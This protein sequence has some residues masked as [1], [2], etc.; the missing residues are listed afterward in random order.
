MFRGLKTIAKSG[1]FVIAADGGIRNLK[2]LGVKPDLIIG[3]FDSSS[4]KKVKR[5]FCKSLIM[6]YPK[7]KDH[8]DTEL[9]IKYA[10]GIGASKITV[11]GALGKR[12]DHTLANIFSTGNFPEKVTLIDEFAELSVHNSSFNIVGRKGQTVSILPFFKN[13]SGVTGSGFKYP[14][15][16]L[17]LR[18]GSHGLSNELKSGRAK[19]NFKKGKILLIKVRKK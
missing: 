13:V 1:S 7:N 19:I 12:I 2:R 10:V 18:A 14:I 6:P 9:A 17:T 8:S 3:D 5:S 11:L 4:L 15:K 16:N